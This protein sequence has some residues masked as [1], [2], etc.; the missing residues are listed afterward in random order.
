MSHESPNVL[1]PTTTGV[2]LQVSLSDISP[3]RGGKFSSNLHR[4]LVRDR[5]AYRSAAFPGVFTGKDGA[6]WIGRW[7]DDYFVGVRLMGV[8]CSGLEAKKFAYRSPNLVQVDDF[9]PKY[10]NVGRC[11]IDPAHEEFF[12]GDETRWRLVED[13]RTCLWC[14]ACVQKRRSHTEQRLVETW[15]TEATA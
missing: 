3:A 14:Q 4:W 15:V 10:A 12:M 11:A 7:H 13:T 9:W 1:V 8:L 5:Q 2:P 6:L